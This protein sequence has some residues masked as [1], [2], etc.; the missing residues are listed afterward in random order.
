MIAPYARYN[1]LYSYAQHNQQEA[2]E[3][4]TSQDWLDI[5]TWYNLTWIGE[6]F[7]S[8]NS[9][10]QSLFEKLIFQKMIK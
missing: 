2:V 5:Q 10:L 7:K 8:N 9:E 4:F 6:L 3:S 1:E